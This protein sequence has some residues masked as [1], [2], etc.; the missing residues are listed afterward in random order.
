MCL[1]THT[2]LFTPIILLKQKKKHCSYD[3]M[4]VNIKL[5][6][7]MNAMVAELQAVASG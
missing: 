7:N 6:I 4:G 1:F 5:G 2:F 3:T